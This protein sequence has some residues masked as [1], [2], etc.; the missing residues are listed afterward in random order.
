MAAQDAATQSS[1]NDVHRDRFEG[2]FA[3][4]HKTEQTFTHGQILYTLFDWFVNQ[5]FIIAQSYDFDRCS[6]RFRTGAVL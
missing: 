3:L 5:K 4:A 1:W 2:R 6:H